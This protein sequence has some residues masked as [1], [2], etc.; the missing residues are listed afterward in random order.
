[1]AVHSHV[2]MNKKVEL[3]GKSATTFGGYSINRQGLFAAGVP[4]TK[5]MPCD[6][7]SPTRSPTQHKQTHSF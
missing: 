2:A 4:P 1:M 5:P 6:A 7:P 3:E